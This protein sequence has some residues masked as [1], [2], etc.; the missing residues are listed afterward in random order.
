M[1]FTTPDC[2]SIGRS[3]ESSSMLASAIG[4]PCGAELNVSTSRLNHSKTDEQIV[5]TT[6]RMTQK[7]NLI[8]SIICEQAIAF[9]VLPTYALYCMLSMPKAPARFQMISSWVEPSWWNRTT[10]L[11]TKSN[12][13]DR[14]AA[15]IH[16]LSKTYLL[17]SPM[18]EESLVTMH[19][20]CR[21]W[22]W[23]DLNS[24]EL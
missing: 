6:T 9:K 14:H 1:C 17:C 23:W 21:D 11:R 7:P 22:W 15:Y 2:P 3:S 24:R 18:A 8:T 12:M 20:L 4:L 16:L 13:T 5:T 19:V 10:R